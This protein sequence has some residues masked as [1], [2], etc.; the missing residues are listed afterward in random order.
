MVLS[1]R[2]LLPLR[3]KFLCR[4][5]V[6]GGWNRKDI[7]SAHSHVNVS[8]Q[9]YAHQQG[10]FALTSAGKRSRNQATQTAFVHQS[11]LL[12]SK[13]ILTHLQEQHA[14]FLSLHSL[15]NLQIHRDGTFALSSRARGWKIWCVAADCSPSIDNCVDEH[16]AL[17]VSRRIEPSDSSSFSSFFLPFHLLCALPAYFICLGLRTENKHTQTGLIKMLIKSNNGSWCILPEYSASTSFQM[18]RINRK[19]ELKTRSICLFGDWSSLASRNKH[20]LRQQPVSIPAQI[21]PN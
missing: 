13:M 18:S 5:L 21:H 6:G 2:S 8:A 14:D 10:G 20:N 1:A 17:Y 3:H 12:E 4:N 9:R 16:V 19:R 11:I 15:S 7:P